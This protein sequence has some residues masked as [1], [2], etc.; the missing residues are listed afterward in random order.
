[1]WL[2]FSQHFNHIKVR[3]IIY[4]QSI[5]NSIRNLNLECCSW[6]YIPPLS[7]ISDKSIYSALWLC[8][9]SCVSV[10]DASTHSASGLLPGRAHQLGHFDECVSLSV[11]SLGVT[12]RYCLADIQV[13]PLTHPD[14][15]NAHPQPKYQPPDNRVSVWERLRVSCL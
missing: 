5:P 1:M 8:C 9:W 10:H 12:G 13:S 2:S 6:K 3:F 15:H 4:V 14:F 7:K 11:P